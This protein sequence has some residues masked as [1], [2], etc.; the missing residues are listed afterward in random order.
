MKLLKIGLALAALVAAPVSSALDFIVN[1]TQDVDEASP[2]NGICNPV[3]AVGT[4][5]TLRAAIMEANAN[6][7]SHNI[8]LPSGTYNLTRGGTGENNA[9][10]GDLDI[11]KPIT[12]ING[13]NNPP[14]INGNYDDRV[15]DIHD[16]GRLTLVNVAVIGGQAN[17]PGTT[18]GGA[19]NVR[20]GA[21]LVLRKARVSSNIANIGGA[22][23]SDGEV[24]V[25]DSDFFFN[26]LTD[27]EVL[28]EFA[29]GAAILNRGSLSIKRSTFRS[30]GVIPGGNGMFLT[31]RYAVHSRRGFVSDPSVKIHNSTF[32]DNTNGIFSDQVFTDIVGTTL[33]NNNFR[34]IRFLP[35][36]DALGQTQLTIAYTVL[37][38]HTGDCNGI[39]DD[40]PEYDVR[41]NINA[42][43]DDS[44]GFTGFNDYQNISYPFFGEASEHGGPTL[45][46]MPRS[47][48]ILVD[49]I[50]G[51]CGAFEDLED[52]RSA[53]R[54]I[55]GDDVSGA[56]CDIGA[57][58]F[59]PETDPGD[60]LF[61]DRFEQD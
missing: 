55:D 56:L 2:G 28:P 49:P 3:G 43:S 4:T 46:F 59:D 33:V 57:I 51:N 19:F 21:A 1:N 25:E 15:F 36:L 6:P 38:G 31:G 32:F 12:I 20:A 27:D 16:G 17:I 37:Y 47:N 53:A 54:P 61:S 35:Y 23:Y 60:S 14:L 8:F 41:F 9:S 52:Q 50:G 11:R 42:S 7:G 45:T 29:N 58:E 39:P 34:G 22:I 44:C 5:C 48:G 24:E 18:T 26:V 30:N 10:T 13:T 40:Q